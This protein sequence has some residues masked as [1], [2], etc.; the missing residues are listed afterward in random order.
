MFN[1]VPTERCSRSST[2][3]SGRRRGASPSR[4]TAG[5]PRAGSAPVARRSTT[6]RARGE[7]RSA[8]RGCSPSCWPG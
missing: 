5:A 4:P 3:A 2:R 8:T 1:T 6:R 7:G